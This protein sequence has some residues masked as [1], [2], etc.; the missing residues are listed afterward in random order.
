MI[1]K[2]WYDWQH[3]NPRNARSFFGGSVQA[4]D[5]LAL[6]EQYPNGAPPYL[7]VSFYSPQVFKERTNGIPVQLS[8]TMPADGLFPEVTIGDVMNTTNGI[9]CYVYE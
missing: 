1:D 3:R 9:L 5:S 2:L 4:V 6:Y 8:S 7:N